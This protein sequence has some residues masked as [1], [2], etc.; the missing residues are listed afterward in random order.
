MKLIKI[1]KNKTLSF[2]MAVITVFLAFT[3]VIFAPVTIS[4]ATETTI[5]VNTQYY[6]SNF[7][8]SAQSRQYPFYVDSP[9]NVN[10]QFQQ[11]TQASNNGS[12]AWRVTLYSYNYSSSSAQ[13]ISTSSYFGSSTST[14]ETG[15][16]SLPSAGS[17]YLEITDIIGSA[18]LTSTYTFRINY[19][20]GSLNSTIATATSIELNAQG[21]GQVNGKTT[22]TNDVNWFR[23]VLTTQGSLTLS[24][25]ISSSMTEGNWKMEL[26]DSNITS[27]SYNPDNVKPL[28]TENVGFGV[29]ASAGY[30]TNTLNK[31][32]L[33]AG[34]YYIK[35]SPYN[36][37]SNTS[38]LVAD[39]TISTLFA[40]EHPGADMINRYESEFNNTRETA[41]KMTLNNAITGSLSDI[42]DIDYFEF[43]IFGREEITIQFETPSSINQSHWS[44]HL[45]N[46][47]AANTSILTNTWGQNGTVNNA[48]RVFVSETITLESGKYRIAVYFTS[49]TW[50]KD[51]NQDYT[52]TVLTNSSPVSSDMSNAV[53]INPTSNGYTT[54]KLESFSDINYYKVTL[55]NNGRFDLYFA[56][57]REIAADTWNVTVY[58]DNARTVLYEDKFGTESTQEDYSGYKTK[59]SDR[60][61]LSKGTYYI[62][63]KAYNRLN[64]TNQ[65]YGLRISYAAEAADNYEQEFNDTPETANSIKFNTDIIANLSN[66]EDIDYYKV[67][68]EN[69]STIQIKFS[70][71]KNINTRHYWQVKIYDAQLKQMSSYPIGGDAGIVN[72]EGLRYYKTSVVSVSPGAYFISVGVH[73]NYDYENDEYIIKILDSEGQ[74]L[75]SALSVAYSYTADTPSSWARAEVERAY[76]YGL[77][78]QSYMKNFT[79]D[80]TREE[81]CVLTMEFLKTYEKKTI[82]E[83]LASRQKQI[84]KTTFSD[85][86]NQT[87]LAAYE[88]G[89]IRGK[90]NKIFDPT[91]KITRE[92]AAIMLSRLG[93]LVGIRENSTSMSF[94]DSKEFQNGTEGLNSATYVS[95]C[96]DN[97]AT[98]VMQGHA[99][100]NFDPLGYYTREQAYL[101][102]IRLFFVK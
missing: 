39:Y 67:T 6:S 62:E 89:I 16:I 41:T 23:F 10:I 98:R 2:F 61:R 44:V 78:P 19:N 80:I 69:T 22:H 58:S 71:D 72:A 75:D 40:S 53:T 35:I 45:M 5:S 97:N 66:K 36:T 49:R 55:E 42:E 59:V 92:E 101:T 83:M 73:P 99:N 74:R 81:F 12:S 24:F 63:V 65:E 21:K 68:A 13:P 31:L 76:A 56:T 11:L 48:K 20:T 18:Y 26:Y 84:D 90:G 38:T 9:G 52:L 93:R 87:I 32:R 57:P 37:S 70:I 88:L 29:T 51:A 47:N 25:S 100:G 15:T 77:I 64:Y 91:G 8:S 60:L 46:S 85:T 7:Y 50:S 27:Y 34:T 14:E 17:Y 86:I 102:M 28:Q 79:N 95:S 3:P 33:P 94:P 43:E 30:R 96:K 54:D 82:D 1:Q 4:A